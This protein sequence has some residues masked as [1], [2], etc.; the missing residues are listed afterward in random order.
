[1]SGQ[2]TQSLQLKAQQQLVMTPQ[3]Q[4]AIK[5]L[6]MNNHELE[7]YLET[8]IETNPLLEK[9][10]DT[11]RDVS[12]EDLGT[13]DD[14]DGATEHQFDSQ[15]EEQGGS[16]APPDSTPSSSD[17]DAGAARVGAG[18]GASFDDPDF[19]FDSNLTETKT[20]RDH[21]TD[22]LQQ[23]MADETDRRIGALLIDM[24]DEAGYLRIDLK[25]LAARLGVTPDRLA[26][27]LQTLRG[28][29]PTG[30]F[31][32]DLI[33]CLRLQ[34]VDQKKLDAPF[35]KLLAHLDLIASHD[36]KKLASLCGVNETYLRDMIA[37]IK[38]LNPKPAAGFM[39]LIVQTAVPD[40]LMKTLPKTSGGGW[41]VE[42][43]TDT[44]PRV[45]INQTYYNNVCAHAKTVADKNYLSTQLND[46]NWIVRALDQR[47]QT[48][49]KVASDIVERQNA[50]FL[51]GIEYLVPMTLKDVADTIGMHEST[52]SRVTTGKFMGTPRGIFELKFFFT[53]GLVGAD[54]TSHSAESVKMKIKQLI[55]AEQADAILSD[56]TI[57]E[58]LNKDGINIARR[59][60][61]KYREGMDIPTSSIRRKIVRNK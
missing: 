7:A 49:L 34:L 12:V 14:N 30:I 4:Q 36:H 1:M 21:L 58:I 43:N 28:F 35:E 57:A 38:T 42:L 18:G 3:L 45:L 56:E 15:W 2:I 25:D 11:P 37:E 22:Q 53:N 19:A 32:H 20:L 5:L 51:Y 16:D 61:A 26:P 17:F 24:V 47:A 50:F 40:V 54:G 13:T 6:Q 44:L 59:T 41:R 39:P 9:A 60:V 10:D 55:D 48:I 27:V 33:D 23:S 52:V 8:Q 29:D 46:A 31:A